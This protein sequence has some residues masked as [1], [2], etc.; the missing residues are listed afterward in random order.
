MKFSEGDQVLAKLPN[1]DEFVK[2]KVVGVKGS[3]YKVQVK[4]GGE[5]SVGEGDLKVNNLKFGNFF[6]FFSTF[7][8]QIQ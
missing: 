1:S 7:H 6:F 8:S 4:G 2:G 3:R 5:H